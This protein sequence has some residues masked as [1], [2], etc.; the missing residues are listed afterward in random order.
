MILQVHY[1]GTGKAEIDRTRV[2]IY[3]SREPIKQALHWST[4]SNSDFQLLAGEANTEGEGE[5]LFHRRRGCP[6]LARMQACS[7]TMANHRCLRMAAT[8]RPDQHPRMGS[9]LAEHLPLPET[10][11]TARPRSIGQGHR[12]LRQLRPLEEPEPTPPKRGRTRATRP[13]TRCG[14]GFDRGRAAKGRRP[15]Q[16]ALRRRT[17]LADPLDD[18][19]GTSSR[20]QKSRAPLSSQSPNGF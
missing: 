18:D 11:V 2:G 9:F 16:L 20:Q 15:W 3:F 1:H 12:P 7:S 6:R 8:S 19:Y 10:P 17:I 14:E 13:T 5:R 4:A